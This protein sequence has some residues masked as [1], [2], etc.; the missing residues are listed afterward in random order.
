[1]L[2]KLST[3]ENTSGLKYDMNFPDIKGYKVLDVNGDDVGEVLDLLVD[4]DSGMVNHAIVGS[5]WFASLFG[6][7]QFVVPFNRMTVNPDTKT[8]MLDIS[9]NE[10]ES[11]PDWSDMD[12]SEP[13]FSAKIADWWDKLRKA[14]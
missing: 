7:R 10:L 9:R 11:F 13:S 8:V 12:I 3:I 4:T 14:A 2:K 1:M 6:G 5:G